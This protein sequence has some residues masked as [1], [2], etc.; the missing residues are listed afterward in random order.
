MLE[1]RNVLG[2]IAIHGDHVRPLAGLY[3]ADKIDPADAKGWELFWNEKY[4]GK[5]SVWNGSASNLEYTALTLGFPQMDA[6]SSDQLSQAK[7]KLIECCGD[8]AIAELLGL[9]SG[10]M[11]AVEGQRGAPEIA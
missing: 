2:R 1:Y 4:S 8:E 5:I 11:E 9:A 10:V 7:Q 6:M 3:R